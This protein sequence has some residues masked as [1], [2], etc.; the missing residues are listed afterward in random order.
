MKSFFLFRVSKFY[1]L[2]IL[3]LLGVTSLSPPAIAETEGDLNICT[4]SF[5]STGR[6]FAP[7]DEL[8]IRASGRINFGFVAGS[9]GPNRKLPHRGQLPLAE[10]LIL[11]AF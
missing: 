10:I 1:E 9:G 3:G 5:V 6:T 7:G 11:Y 4:N 2:M 8:D